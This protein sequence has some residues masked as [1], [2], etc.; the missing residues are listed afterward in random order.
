[1]AA[2]ARE[3]ERRDATLAFFRESK[4]TH[5]AGELLGYA[6]DGSFLT[7]GVPTLITFPKDEAECVALVDHAVHHGLALVPRGTGSGTAGAALAPP[8]SVLVDM[9]R[10]GACDARG[11]RHG[12]FAPAIVRANGSPVDLTKAGPDDELYVRVGAGRTSDEMNR[13]LAEHAWSVAVVPSSGYSTFGGNFAT[14]ARGSGTPA[15]GAF[16]DAVCRVRI[17]ATSKEGARVL[18][19]TDRDE[20]RR[21]AGHH[22]LFGLVTELDVRIAPIPKPEDMVCAILSIESVDVGKLGATIGGLMKR[23]AASC[24]Y[25][26]GEFLFIDD[27][28]VRPDDPIRKDSVLGPYFTVTPGR[29]RMVLL[30]RGRK[31]GM[32]ALP[33]IA[34]EFPDVAYREI[35]YPQFRAMMAVRTAATGKALHRVNVPGCED[36]IIHDPERFGDALSRMFGAMA[37]ASGRPVGHHYPDGIEV[38]YRPQAAVTRADIEAAWVLIQKLREAVLRP[39]LTV[40]DRK[41]HGLGLALFRDGP[42]SRHEELRRLKAVYDPANVF[43]PHLLLPDTEGRFV[44]S[45]FHI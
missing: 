31:A 26:A 7:L 37:G 11:H 22:G 39:E 18:E 20:I 38:H 8:G 5:Q 12:L 4:I 2:I 40:E 14:N 30:Y 25:F 3:Q 36:F 34:A 21:L 19:V 17:V 1:M 24:R 35:T 29:R 42:P 43:C 33:R 45:S 44:G 32:E 9:E 28:I 27:G 13:A 15:F 41:E 10:V 6:T 16:G 23:V